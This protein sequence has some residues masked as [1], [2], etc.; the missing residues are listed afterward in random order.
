M[1]F[2][3]LTLPLLISHAGADLVAAWRFDENSGSVATD[4]INGFNGTWVPGSN[5]SPNW[6]PASGLFGGAIDFPGAG[7]HQNFFRVSNFAALENGSGLTISVW[8]QPQGQSGYRGIFMTRDVTDSDSGQNY[9]IGHEDSHLDGRI[10]GSAVDTPNGT[11]PVSST[12]IH[13]ALVWNKSSGN[14]RAYI[15]GQPSG[16]PNTASGFNINASGEWRIADDACCNGRNFNGLMDDLAVWNEP[17]SDAEVRALYDNGLNG[18]IAGENPPLPT[19]DP[20]NVGLVIN[21]IHYDSDP[22][23]DFVEFLEILNTNDTPLDISGYRFTSGITF[24]FPPNTILPPTGYLLLAENPSALTAKFSLLPNDVPILPYTGNLDSDGETITLETSTGIQIDRVKYKDEFPWPISTDGDGDSMQLMN[25]T[26]DNDL[27]GAWQGGFPTPGYQNVTFAENTAPQI[28]QV[29]H[30]PLT[31]AA[32]QSTTI[33]TK[34]DDIQ[35][36]SSVTLTYQIVAPGSYISAFLPLPRGIVQSDPTRNRDPNPDFENP[37]NWTTLTMVDDGTNGDLLAGDS[38]FTATLPAQ[39]HRTLVRYRITATDTLSKSIRAP[40]ADDPSL[41]FAYFSYNGVPDYTA[42]QH[43]VHPDGPGHVYP[44]SLLTSIP[45][46]HLI[47]DPDDLAQCWAY[48]SADRVGS[49]EARKAYNWEGT[50]VYEGVVYDHLNYRLRQ[51]NDRYAGQGRR[52]MKFRFNDGHYFQARNPE[53]Q[54]Y[55]FKWRTMNTSKMTRFGS[56][57]SFGLREMTSSRLWNLAGVIAPEFQHVHFRVIDGADEAP[58]QYHGDFYGLSMVF[59]DADAQFLKERNLPKGNVYKLKDGAGD[60]KDLQKYQA[61]TAVTDAS[62]FINIRDNLGPPT[63]SD[64]WLR[65]NVDWDRWYLYASLGEGFRHYD[66]SPAFQKN[67]IWYFT[68]SPDN[69][70]GKMSVIPH[71]TDA[72]WGYGTNDAQWDDPRYSG[73]TLPDGS[74]YRGRVVGIDLPKEAIQ[75]ITGLDGTDGENH[76]EREAFMLEYRNVIREVSDLLWHPETVHSEMHRAYLNIA[77]FS[78]ADRDRWDKGPDD[79]GNENMVAIGNILNP[80]KNLAFD[81]DLYMGSVLT[82]GRAERLRQLAIDDNIP[83]KPIL[84]YTG[85]PDYLPGSISFSTTSFDDP[86]GAGTFAA[87]EWRVAEVPPPLPSTPTQY[88]QTGHLWKYFDLGTDPGSTWS[89]ETFDDSTWPQGPSELGYGDDQTTEVG[90][91]DLDPGTFGNQRNSTTFFRS[92]VTIPDANASYEA[93]IKFD[94][95]AVVFINGEEVYRAEVADDTPAHLTYA[96]SNRSDENA[97]D[98]FLIPSD[99]L[100]TGPNTVA[101]SIHQNSATSSDISFDM[102]L[103]DQTSFFINNVHE[104]HPTWESGPLTSFQSATLIPAAATRTGSTYRA[105][106]RHQDTSGRWSH[107]SDPVEFIA[108]QPD[109]SDFINALVVSEI[110]YHPADLTQPERDAGF[111]DPDQFEYLEIRNVSTLPID[112]TDV[113]FTKG[114]DFDFVNGTITTLPAGGFALIVRDQT[115]FALR[116][117]SGHPVAGTFSGKLSNSEDFVKLSFGAGEPIREFTYY[118]TSPW[119]TGPDGGGY[120]LTLIN[121]RSLPNH[122]D[123][124]NWRQ[125]DLIG[126]MPGS[127]DASL[128]TGTTLEELKTY[129]FDNSTPSLS[130]QNGGITFSL[131]TRL[132]SDNLAYQ[133][134]ASSDLINWN[135]PTTFLTRTNLVPLPNGLA[136]ATYSGTIPPEHQKLFLRYEASQ[137]D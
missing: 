135:L 71:D 110:M 49:V 51:R 78:L 99:V 3:F 88:L 2:F 131:I 30:T 91:I 107:W 19:T 84:T 34:V 81:A 61:R 68:P 26:V 134:L 64:Q 82:G 46:Y 104:W 32:S 55:N 65:D 121:P 116:Y 112:L 58:D 45:V 89:A 136:R 10:S 80:I 38:I 66:F 28:R 8:L 106:V 13:A 60:P 118:D 96:D 41:N 86:Q 23:T 16:S 50:F 126:G 1:K 42:S 133:I 128:F 40:F 21:E 127:L 101:V 4:S 29:T 73:G 18:I 92:T 31:P 123:P 77:A 6:Q 109:A 24:Q 57:S 15:N 25:A 27:G 35:G 111:T 12:W 137:E 69:P 103:Q 124:F 37:A 72:T 11:L 20:L 119:P 39:P 36:V 5:S 108:G 102:I 7:N 59:E 85:H 79:A 48:D 100:K 98:T 97:Y 75:E 125:S 113:R 117:G 52:S 63:Q 9:G 132:D 114:V 120:S 33:T 53:G 70:L 115:A 90:F 122:D 62:D 83:A 17:L 94:D 130:S 76:P 54:K 95:G 14:Y 67:R 105:R 56:N 47:T 87:L 74:T 43:S 129:A 93:Q 22:K 44:S